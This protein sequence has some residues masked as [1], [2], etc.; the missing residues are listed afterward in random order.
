MRIRWNTKN[1]NWK[2]DLYVWWKQFRFG[3]WWDSDYGLTEVIVYL[4][5]W[6]VDVWKGKISKN[7]DL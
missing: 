1:N 4:G 5:F 2:V 6:N 3:F 7:K